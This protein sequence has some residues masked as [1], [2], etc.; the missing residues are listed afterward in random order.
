VVV[1]HLTHM[2]PGAAAVRCVA[3]LALLKAPAI[4]GRTAAIGS[5]VT[6][7]PGEVTTHQW[8]APGGGVLI[9]ASII[10]G[11]VTILATQ[12]ASDSDWRAAS[13]VLGTLHTA[14]L[15]EPEFLDEFNAW[16]TVTAHAEALT[17]A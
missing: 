17:A 6:T 15:G 5:Q 1:E 3:T 2:I 16:T 7:A 11:L 12:D 4:F 14:P 10:T 8:L 9:E 13:A